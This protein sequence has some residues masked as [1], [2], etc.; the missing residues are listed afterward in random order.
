ML[1]YF[2][3]IVVSVLVDSSLREKSTK[4]LNKR[5]QI[6]SFKRGFIG[7]FMIV[8]SLICLSVSVCVL[9]LF[10]L[11]MFRR[12]KRLLIS[13]PCVVE[14]GQAQHCLEQAGRRRLCSGYREKV[15]IRK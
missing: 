13:P 3:L 10:M 9:M 1:I 7:A 11:L 8:A 14:E 15:A 2:Q 5:L 4:Q 6:S 12:L